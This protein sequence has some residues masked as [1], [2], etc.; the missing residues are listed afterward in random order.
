MK[1]L[2]LKEILLLILIGW[3]LSV[4]FSSL[5]LLNIVENNKHLSLLFLIILEL[6]FIVPSIIF[7]YKS[8]YSYKKYFKLNAISTKIIFPLII[9]SIGTVVLG[10]AL[11]RIINIY[12]PV[13]NLYEEALNELI[14]N[15]ISSFLIIIVS[16]VFLAPIVE[17][18]IFRGLLLRGLEKKYDSIIIPIIYSSI[19]FTTIHGLPFAFIQIF[20]FG[21][22]LGLLSITLNSIITGIILHSINNLFMILMLNY[23]IEEL[24]FYLKGSIVNWYFILIAGIFIYFGFIKIKSYIKS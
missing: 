1:E 15:D 21:I 17:E 3:I 2:N 18:M 8:N 6:I 14:W 16:V 12:I 7:I 4:S 19:L 11:D 24:N 13:P 9:F 22:I 10:D 23:G 20:I 5:Q